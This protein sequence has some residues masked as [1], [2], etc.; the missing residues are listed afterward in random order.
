[1][2]RERAKLDRV[3]G[4]IADLGRLRYSLSTLKRE[5][6]RVMKKPTNWVSRCLLSATRTRKTESR[7]SS[8]FL[9]TAPRSPIQ[10]IVSVI[11]QN[12]RDG[13]SGLGLTKRRRPPRKPT[14]LAIAEAAADEKN[15]PFLAL[16]EGGEPSSSK[17]RRFPFSIRGG[18][19][20]R[21]LPT[22]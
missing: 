13:L 14:G 17:I 5:T 2:T 3:L 18:A 21:Q 7:H 15:S 4:G 22:F 16:F 12:H 1:M 20:E 9:P 6:H 19:K 10:L 8:L 11:Q